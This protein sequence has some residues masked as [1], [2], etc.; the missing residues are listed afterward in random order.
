MIVGAGVDV[1][2]VP[3][4][5]AGAVFEVVPVAPDVVAVVLDDLV[6]FL[7]FL[8]GAVVVVV[9]PEP[10]VEP[11]NRACAAV[12]AWDMASMSDW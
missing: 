11:G 3:A 12:S 5:P 7:A 9:A 2:V 4:V 1:T 6:E 10:E 8:A